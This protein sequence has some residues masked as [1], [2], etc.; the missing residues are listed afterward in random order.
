MINAGIYT[1]LSEQFVLGILVG[2]L[3]V[4]T[5]SSEYSTRRGR[6]ST[7]QK[8]PVVGAST[9]SSASSILAVLCFIGAG[10]QILGFIGVARVCTSFE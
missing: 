1:T 7:L 3:A 8:I 6:A 10:V 9:P 4:A 2:V 5:P